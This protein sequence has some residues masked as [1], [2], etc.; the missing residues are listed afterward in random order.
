MS[1]E[2]DE[3]G[4]AFVLDQVNSRVEVFEPGR[5]P[6]TIALPG[7]TFQDLALAK[8]DGIILIDRLTTGSVA[9]V[10][11][12]GKVSHEIAVAGQGIE[13]GGDVTAMTSRSDGVWLE[14]K[15]ANL[16]RVADADGNPLEDREIV[17]GR[18][19]ADGVSVMRASRSGSHAAF[20]SVK[21]PD[22]PVTAL[23]RVSFD[24][25]IHEI[26]GLETDKSGRIFLGVGLIEESQNPP[27]DILRS[28]EL[29]V[30]LGA[31]GAELA[32]VEFPAS[33]G[34]EESFR[35]IRLGADG[36]L[37]HL[38]FDEQGATLAKVQL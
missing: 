16:V 30:V 19:A 31:N 23:A 38:G 10:D 32:R 4:R 22:K 2:V 28:S 14:V 17:Q 11:K 18:F 34:P 24:L 37:Y 26:L 13:E 25:T 15:H 12:T 20:V 1:F 8:N 29:V 33:T 3:L 27:F 35:R 9:Y 7:D 5:E 21:S 36:S 6:R